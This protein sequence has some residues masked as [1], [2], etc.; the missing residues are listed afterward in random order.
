MLLR[1]M[2]I[3][4]RVWLVVELAGADQLVVNVV[5]KEDSVLRLEQGAVWKWNHDAV[6]LIEGWERVR[7]HSSSVVGLSS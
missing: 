2:R 5:A 7:R 1:T 6:G 4:V 3:P